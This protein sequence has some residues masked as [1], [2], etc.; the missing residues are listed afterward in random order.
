MSPPTI[1][2][3]IFCAVVD[4]F[5]D[6]GVCWRLARQLA[7]EFSWQVRLL[8]DDSSALAWLAPDHVQTSVGIG[9]FYATPY[10]DAEVVIEAFA[11]QIPEA[12]Q[13]AMAERS[14]AP[15]WINLEYLSAEQWV[16]ESHGLPS[17][18]PRSGLTKHFFFPGF[19]AKTGG[20]IRER[21]YDQRR[22]GFDAAMFRARHG[23][24]NAAPGELLV[25]LFFYPN[26][27]LHE[28]Y[29][30]CSA[31]PVPIVAIVPG[32]PAPPSIHGNLRVLPL[33][34]L[35]QL[36]YDQLLWLCD[37][38]FVR[39]EDSL[40]RAQW[41]GKPM[42]WQI[43]PQQGDAHL[44]KLDSFLSRYLPVGAH[45]TPLRNLMMAWNGQGDPDWSAVAARLP[46]LNS[47]AKAWADTLRQHP[48]LATNLRD[49]CLARLKLS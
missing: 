16:T 39:G 47:H 29:A 30:A 46:Q 7:T 43:Y 33:P 6:V 36:D 8:V 12:Y 31:S 41:A 13:A 32:S 3:D 19:D 48:D 15:V 5:G 42:V 9:R 14:T 20:L 10:S 44:V 25:S 1:R 22:G 34:F 4:N 26:A 28:L 35:S 40:V 49:F 18:H 27:P 45:S 24:P 37:L 38:N 17:I 2:C 21:D 23:L 11:C